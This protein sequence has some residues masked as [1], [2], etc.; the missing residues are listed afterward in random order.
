M[1]IL[2]AV[3]TL[4]AAALSAS[5]QTESHTGLRPLLPL[6]P[7]ASNRDLRSDDEDFD[8][9]P[10][11]PVA[12]LVDSITTSDAEIEVILGRSRIITLKAPLGV[13][14]GVPLVAVGDPTV[15]D[16]DVVGPRH[17]RIVTKRV[18]VSD[19]TVTTDNGETYAFD[20]RVV[21][22]L[23]LLESYLHQIFPDATIELRQLREH[24]VLAG[25]A[26][27]DI[28]V[29]R[30][31]DTL[32]VYLS[33]MQ[34][35]TKIE[36]GSSRRPGD[37]PGTEGP[38]QETPYDAERQPSGP[39][40]VEVP[41][42]KAETEAEFPAAQIINLMTVPGVQQVMLKV[43]IAE[44]NRTSLRRIGA[45]IAVRNNGR[46]VFGSFLNPTNTLAIFPSRDVD[47]FL[48]ALRENSVANVLAEPTLVAMHGEEASF[49]AGGEFPFTVPQ[50]T[51]NNLVFSIQFKP[52]GVQLNFVPY[53]LDENTIRLRV[54]PEVSSIN[55]AL[56]VSLGAGIAVPGLDTRAV[57]T[58][59]EL[60]QGQTLAIGGLLQVTLEAR[61]Q[62]IPGVGD[63]PY[64]GPFFSNT[65]HERAEKELMVLVTPYLVSPL[66]GNAQ[67]CLPG[68]EILDP[69]D[70]EFYFLNRIEGRTG[71]P[72]RSPTAWDN[73]LGLVQKL[74]LER[75][76]VC[77]PM[78]YSQ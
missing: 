27:S 46:P 72:F 62:R 20:I 33:S 37:V 29:M 32:K 73:P 53:I 30:I 24:V 26:R 70:C 28:E 3:A 12:G 47:F 49:L 10:R 54:A 39:A 4:C 65:S 34:P 7:P 16:F 31:V 14:Q 6:A 69:N 38:P 66:D 15:L 78:G 9:S 35:K 56:T 13:E 25:Q 40:P 2:L 1:R 61:T 42:E 22:D 21:Y 17:L 41:D 51:G 8:A 76:A 50:T 75:A 74:K 77:G 68:E 48:N 55:E 60:S 71:R 59:V 52:F 43:Q 63:L 64:I 11:G 19:F 67:V 45:D 23:P 44:L 57:N 58:T 36:G 5:A 18:G